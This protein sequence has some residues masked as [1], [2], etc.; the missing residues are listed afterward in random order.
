MRWLPRLTLGLSVLALAACTPPDRR[1]G[2]YTEHPALWGADLVTLHHGTFSDSARNIRMRSQLMSDG[3]LFVAHLEYPTWGKRNREIEGLLDEHTSFILDY[4]RAHPESQ[5]VLAGFSQ[6]GCVALDL[7]VR[8]AREDLALLDRA[9]LLLVAP[10]RGVKLAGH[11]A[12]ARRM[13]TRC[14]LAEAEI[15]ALIELAPEGEVARLLGER[16]FLTWSCND[17]I[18]GHDSFTTLPAHIPAE[19][20]LYQRR[21][22]HTPW[23]AKLHES[24]DPDAL[25]GEKVQ[26]ASAL[27][28][29]L[30]ER[31]DPHEALAPYVS[32]ES[33][34]PEKKKNNNNNE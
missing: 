21:L 33:G 11:S 18:V 1:A 23:V 20:I 8:I 9:S 27:V 7:L 32:F 3:G 26:L 5:L 16:T 14:T 34:C 6:G 19:H 17:A 29:V 24:L 2:L 30:A 28:R 31:R 10:A 12:L 22:G 13:I 4:L 25:Y 15:E